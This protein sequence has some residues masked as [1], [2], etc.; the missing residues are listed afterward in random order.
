MIY[1][2]ALVSGTVVQIYIYIYMYIFIFRFFFR[3][4]YYRVLSRV[5]CVIQ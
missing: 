2:V 1:N 3:V 5:P 4:G